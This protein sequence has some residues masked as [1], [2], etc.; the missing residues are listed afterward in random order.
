MHF[1]TV[2]KTHTQQRHRHF[3]LMN[4]RINVMERYI[5]NLHGIKLHLADHRLAIGSVGQGLL[6]TIE[7]EADPPRISRP[8]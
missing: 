4:E 8:E 6:P 2:Q 3:A 7:I 5:A 1:H